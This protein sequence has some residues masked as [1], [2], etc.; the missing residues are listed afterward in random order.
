M[1][2]MVFMILMMF[3]GVWCRGGVIRSIFAMKWLVFIFRVF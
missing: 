1:M 3:F 2:L